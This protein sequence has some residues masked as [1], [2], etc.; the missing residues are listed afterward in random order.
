MV[1]Q[2]FFFFL[3]LLTGSELRSCMDYEFGSDALPI[4]PP[5]HPVNLMVFVTLSLMH[6][7]NYCRIVF[8]LLL[9]VQDG[10]KC[11]RTQKMIGSDKPAELARH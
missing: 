11:S 2:K 8:P 4:G 6:L 10:F 3:V 7:W 5:C 9:A 1:T